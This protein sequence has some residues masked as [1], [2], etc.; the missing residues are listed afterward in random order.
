MRR[1]IVP[2]YFHNCHYSFINSPP[3]IGDPQRPNSGLRKPESKSA[4]TYFSLL[5][6]GLLTYITNQTNLH[7]KLHPLCW[8][9]INGLTLMLIGLGH[10][11][12]ICCNRLRVFAQF[13]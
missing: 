7:A 2:V 5:F 8:T 1:H 11:R 10:F 13:S 3:L 6:D 12:D 9:T 4:Y